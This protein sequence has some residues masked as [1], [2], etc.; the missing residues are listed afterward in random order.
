MRGEGEVV[1]HS[2]KVR[3][4]AVPSARLTGGLCPGHNPAGLREVQHARGGQVPLDVHEEL[5]VVQDDNCVDAELAGRVEE[6]RV[7]GPLHPPAGV[8]ETARVAR[9][10]E[11]LV[12][13]VHARRQL[14]HQKVVELGVASGTQV[15]VVEH[16][17][18]LV[19]E[20][21]RRVRGLVNNLR[22]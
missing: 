17:R 18:R 22:A 11:G 5:L 4:R 10:R 2:V 1:S 20:P 6:G 19:Q 13:E 14:G 3:P 16:E 12:S 9:L 15:S 8:Y 7:P 21:Q